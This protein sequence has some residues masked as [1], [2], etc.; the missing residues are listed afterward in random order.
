MSLLLPALGIDHGDARI[1]IAATDILGMM[2][3]PVETIT[4]TQTNAL[5]ALP[6]LLS[7]DIANV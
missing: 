1:G 4:L 7:R 5:P 6:S 2:A 3:H